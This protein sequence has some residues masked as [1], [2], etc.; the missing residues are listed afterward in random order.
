M[1]KDLWNRTCRSLIDA[2]E[3][4]EVPVGSGHGSTL[5]NDGTPYQIAVAIADARQ[6]SKFI[7][8][9]YP[10]VSAEAQR[11][12]VLTRIESWLSPRCRLADKYIDYLSCLGWTEDELANR[13]WLASNPQ[14]TELEVYT[15]LSGSSRLKRANELSSLLEDMRLDMPF[16]LDGFNFGPVSL[17]HDGTFTAYLRP[18]TTSAISSIIPHQMTRFLNIFSDRTVGAR[19]ILIS[20]K[21]T[22]GHYSEIKV[23]LC[24]H[25][26]TPDINS[27]A[28]TVSRLGKI[29]RDSPIILPEDAKVAFWGVSHE[30]VNQ[31]YYI[32]TIPFQQRQTNISS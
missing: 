13:F 27:T 6:V 32:Y 23:D 4:F 2:Q 12:H 29:C 9:P 21:F 30:G 8:D 25:C 22:D 19:G 10:H 14:R 3:H 24:A 18:A 26:V 15:S 5:N 31:R 28:E 20:V 1:D 11:K 7:V 16:S 17:A